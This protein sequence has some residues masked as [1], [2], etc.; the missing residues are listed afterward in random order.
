MY[1][2]FCCVVVCLG[3]ICKLRHRMGMQTH[4]VSRTMALTPLAMVWLALRMLCIV[5]MRLG[6]QQAQTTRCMD[7][8]PQHLLELVKFKSSF[9]GSQPL[10]PNPGCRN[11]C[12]LNSSPPVIGTDTDA[13]HPV[14]KHMVFDHKSKK[15]PSLKGYFNPV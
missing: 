10:W 13:L 8:R 14:S 4:G 15:R 9:S 5:S 7:L 2:V 6:S 3:G 1:I 11:G 12:L